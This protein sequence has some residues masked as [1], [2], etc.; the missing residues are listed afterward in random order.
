M[1]LLAALGQP[2]TNEQV[3][4]PLTAVP[5]DLEMLADFLDG[6]PLQGNGVVDLLTGDVYPPGVLDWDRPEE[7]DEN[8]DS[9]DP[10]RW[11][12]FQPE[13]GEGYR[14]MCDFAVNLPEGELRDRLLP[15]LDGRGAFRRFRNALDDDAYRDQLTN[16]T[17]FGD[18]RRLGRARE[19]LAQAGYRSVQ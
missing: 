14:D 8:S 11:L 4:W 12:H 17:L 19:W 7:L 13:S 10:D 1:E 6:D 15:A 3:P 2:I 5:V 18:E 9:F 16:W